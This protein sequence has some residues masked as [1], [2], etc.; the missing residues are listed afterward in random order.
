MIRNGERESNEGQ[1]R[2]E[3]YYIEGG[4]ESRTR[5][6]KIDK[7]EIGQKGTRMTKLVRG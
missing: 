1:E 7:G 4:R 3:K 5:E 2:K 6:G